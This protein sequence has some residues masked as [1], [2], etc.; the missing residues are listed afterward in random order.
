MQ[1]PSL[2]SIRLR[3]D[4][5][6]FERED[7]ERPDGRL[8]DF[9]AAEHARRGEHAEATRLMW[10]AFARNPD[11]DAY[12]KLAE[13]AEPAGEWP[14]R[15]ER[16]LDL[17]RVRLTREV[18]Q[19]PPAFA[20]WRARD[21]SE[22][23]RIFLWEGDIDAA[24]REAREGGCAPELWLELAERRRSDHP[25]D[26]LVVYQG[27]IEPT[28]ERKNHDAYRQAVKHLGEVQSL[29]STLGREEDFPIYVTDLRQRH[30]RKRNLVK[31]LDAL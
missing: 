29:L 30:K 8:V 31:L 5:R 26:A 10:D 13:R 24:W 3:S 20:V 16:A 27:R 7:A 14:E 11:L 18:A 28:I 25:E 6:S 2:A 17:L 19:Q 1:V 21:R 9:L 12:R 4:G 23:V 15:R 22:L